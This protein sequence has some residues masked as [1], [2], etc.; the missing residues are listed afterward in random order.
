MIKVK[1]TYFFNEIRGKIRRL[2]YISYLY[3]KSKNI[4]QNAKYKILIIDHFFSGE[5][6]AIN[7]VRENFRD[8]E[9]LVIPPEP[10][11]S[12][13]IHLFP[14]EIRIAKVEYNNA[15][16]EK[17]KDLSQKIST[18]LFYDIKKFFDFNCIITPSDSFYWLREFIKISQNNNIPTI[19]ADKEGTISPLS[20]ET[21]P[22]RIKN[23]FPP[24]SNYFFVWSQRQKEFWQKAGVPPDK[25]VITGS[26]RT[27]LFVNMRKLPPKNVIFFDF[28][29]DAYINII[30]WNEINYNGDKN[31]R[32]LRN[33]FRNILKILA[34]KFKNIEFIL[35]THPQQSSYEFDKEIKN[36]KNV[37]IFQ[38][39]EISEKLS[40]SYAVVGFQTTALMESVLAKIPTIY[41]A[42][43][44]L[45]KILKSKLLPFHENGFGMFVC[46]NE[47]EVIKIIEN[48]LNGAK[49]ELPNSNKLKMF[50]EY[51][52]GKCTERLLN[53]LK[54]ILNK[55]I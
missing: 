11:F 7:C 9:F 6:K 19:V 21:E 25:I 31:W 46:N 23:F 15:K 37:K 16:V 52:D 22:I 24:I 30:N 53:E 49:L 44:E 51:M 1:E 2:Q 33:S 43:G 42:W 47:N 36:L 32:Y 29:I 13:I 55:N 28:D 39:R 3:K 18:K 35:K 40:E 54:K 45:Y 27:D 10:F 41:M 4:N 8:M 48:I 34:K 38:G 20:F 12:K 17:F 14:Q 5:I 50:F 26:M